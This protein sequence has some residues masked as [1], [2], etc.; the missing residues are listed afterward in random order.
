MGDVLV[1]A[2]AALLVGLVLGVAWTWR[3]VR[4][5]ALA[6]RDKARAFEVQIR[7]RAHDF[8]AAWND[9]GGVKSEASDRTFA[10]FRRALGEADTELAAAEAVGEWAAA[11]SR[12]WESRHRDGLVQASREVWMQWADDQLAAMREQAEE[13]HQ[14]ERI[15]GLAAE[16]AKRFQK[17]EADHG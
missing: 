9:A 4:R 7:H 17:Q 12:W 1:A 14:W 6:A 2:A 13:L 3:S 10:A 8:S 16:A 15:E 5:R 11:A